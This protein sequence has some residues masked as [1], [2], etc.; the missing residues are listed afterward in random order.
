M[1][2]VSQLPSNLAAQ[3]LAC[4]YTLVSPF[5]APQHL[6]SPCTATMVIDVRSITSCLSLSLGPSAYVLAS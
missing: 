2:R 3:N 5:V 4:L 1:W 6:N